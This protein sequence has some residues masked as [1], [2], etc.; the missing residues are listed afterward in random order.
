MTFEILAIN[1]GSTS[2]KIAVFKD[3]ELMFEE[4]IS[5]STEEL[6]DFKTIFDQYPFRKRIILDVLHKRNY[7]IKNLSAVVGR[8]GL[9][10]PVEGGTYKVNEKMLEDLKKG[11]LGEHASNL[12]G[13]L[14]YEIASETGIPSFIVDP[15]VVDEM[16]PIAKITGV[17]EIKRK[18]IFHA[19]NQKAVAKRYAKSI[20]KRY[21]ELN[22]I[23]AHMGGGITVGAH[24]KGRVVD[25]NN[26]LD[27]EGPFSPERSGQLPALDFAKL[28]LSKNMNLEEIKKM[29]AGKGGLVAYFGTNDAREIGKRID[30][31]NDEAKLVY[32]AMAYNIA[33][34][35]G[36]C[37]AVLSG[38]VD[39][40][41]LTGGL[42][43]DSKLVNWIKERISFIAPVEIFPG[44]DELK[45]LAEGA[46]RVLR[47]EEAAKEYF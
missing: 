4:K 17:P 42:A 24:K 41:I 37:A 12:G 3:E 28:I 27:G 47:G 45:A 36:A 23:V 13:V 2:T 15:V 14:A 6:R 29:I 18:S 1:P 33:K 44:E 31:G 8:G 34:E 22:L 35:I 38:K 7:N 10:K 11:V 5:H 32:E 9:I 20:G 25:V 21:E 19:L 43:Y 39:A 26:G 30:E 16:E 46:L 40:V